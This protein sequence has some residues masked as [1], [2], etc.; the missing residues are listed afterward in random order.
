MDRTK[1]TFTTVCITVMMMLMLISYKSNAQIIIINSN[2][3]FFYCQNGEV[4][5][6][7]DIKNNSLV[8]IEVACQMTYIDVSPVLPT[9][10]GGSYCFAGNCY[11]SGYFNQS[12]VTILSAG[13]TLS[14]N[15]DNDGFKALFY[16]G[17]HFYSYKIE[18]CFFDTKNALNRSCITITYDCNGSVLSSSIPINTQPTSSTLTIYNSVGAII[19][20]S[21]ISNDKDIANYTKSLSKGLYLAVNTKDNN[22]ISTQ[23]LIITKNK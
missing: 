23:K 1:M 6:S 3:D 19:S 20:T 10:A 21:I 16:S 17:E 8:D 13:S 22:I 12:D 7:I 2:S 4:Q 9:W 5:H 18:Y 15:D 14:F 11:S